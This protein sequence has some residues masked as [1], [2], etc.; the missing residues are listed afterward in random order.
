M[1]VP[2]KLLAETRLYFV[3]DRLPDH[4]WTVEQAFDG[5]VSCFVVSR[6][7]F[8]YVTIDFDHRGFRSGIAGSGRMI[9]GGLNPCC[10]AGRGWSKFLVDDAIAWLKNQ[11]ESNKS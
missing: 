4:T 2:A 1:K 9:K 8:G 10:Y 6:P 11:P 3:R 7:H 5:V